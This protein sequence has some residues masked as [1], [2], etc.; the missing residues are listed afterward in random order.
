MSRARIHSSH[1]QDSPQ[2]F[3]SLIPTIVSYEGIVR[4]HTYCLS[5]GLLWL[6]WVASP[7]MDWDVRNACISFLTQI[8]A[9]APSLIPAGMRTYRM[10]VRYWG[11]CCLPYFQR[12]CVSW[13]H[14]TPLFFARPRPQLPQ[15]HRKSINMELI[16]L[17][18]SQWNV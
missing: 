11:I 17:L 6:R 16:D 8:M 12:K 4:R 7:V 5:T 2:Q 9:Q 1:K 14:T 15:H 13:P 18:T 10:H 3:A